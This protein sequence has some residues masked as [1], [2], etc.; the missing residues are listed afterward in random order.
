MQERFYW[1]IWTCDW[2]PLTTYSYPLALSKVI[3]SPLYSIFVFVEFC[4]GFRIGML[5]Q[6]V[7][8]NDVICVNMLK[9][10]TNNVLGTVLQL[11]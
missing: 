7:L 2:K 6:A 5:V 9:C 4:E 3:C 10:L 1:K 8:N 11:Q